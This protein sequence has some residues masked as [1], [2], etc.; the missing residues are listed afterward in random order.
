VDVFFVLSGFLIT[1]LLLTEFDA[2]GRIDLARFWGRR[3]RRLLPAIMVLIVCIALWEATT[4]A[5]FELPLRR[6]DLLWALFYGSNWHLIGS[7]QD[8]FAAY[9]SASMVRH[10][11][12]LSI[13]EQFYLA[14]PL[15]VILAAWIG[16]GRTRVFAGI[17][18][19]GIAGSVTSMALLYSPGNPSRS[20]YGTESRA[21][22]LL[23]GALVGVLVIRLRPGAARP[24]LGNAIAVLSG[25]LLLAAFA[26]FADTNAAYY[27]GGS[28]L[29]AICTGLLI[30]GLEVAPRGPAARL[31]SFR[32]ARSVGMVSYGIY[33]WHWPIILV[34]TSP[35]PLLSWLPDPL[36]VDVSRTVLIGMIATL[37][38][39]MVERPIRKGAFPGLL[40]SVPR[41]CAVV[42]VGLAIVA[43]TVVVLT[44]GGHTANAEA[45][46][47][48]VEAQSTLGCELIICLRHDGGRGAP[49]LALI[50][51]STARSLDPGLVDLAER[52]RWTYVMAASDGCRVTHLLS[53]FEGISDPYRPCYETTTALFSN[54]IDEWQPDIVVNLD[55]FEVTSFVDENGRIVEA[56]TSSYAEAERR[57]LTELT[58]QLTSSGATV[59]HVALPPKVFTPDSLADCLE[60]GERCSP[61]VKDDPIAATYNRILRGVAAEIDQASY[62]SM[63]EVIC[64]DDACPAEIDGI[65]VR[66]DGVH[67]TED[68]AR[69][70]AERLHREMEQ[71]GAL[72]PTMSGAVT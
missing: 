15:L 14:W 62:V 7:S 51:D 19:V 11:W 53:R 70:L 43:T 72:P 30:W 56:G 27:R 3:A 9:G 46:Q 47:Q 8:Y 22:Q 29:V 5:A 65:L 34:V 57:G 13:E 4:A 18:V 68:A 61:P 66:Y 33:L 36:D 2:T 26:G 50:G 20:Y 55:R 38:F 49:V 71:S 45:A 59:F 21:H 31:L 60:R 52:M 12:S 42:V 41:L 58:E 39:L 54:L 37:S 48:A 35:L 44:D 24:R 64:P 17:C 23:I 10:T 63:N 16:R 67:F 40:R 32:P 1:S 25:I 28:T 6:H 69:W